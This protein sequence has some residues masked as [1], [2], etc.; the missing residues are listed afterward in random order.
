[1]EFL[2]QEIEP[3]CIMQ[4]ECFYAC[5]CAMEESN[6]LPNANIKAYHDSRHVLLALCLNPPYPP[7]SASADP[8]YLL[9]A[10]RKCTTHLVQLVAKPGLWTGLD[11]GL[12]SVMDLQGR[13]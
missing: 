5:I 2:Q 4:E 8:F 13:F 7:I 1:M 11:Y 10:L 3:L 12:D 9:S 6:S